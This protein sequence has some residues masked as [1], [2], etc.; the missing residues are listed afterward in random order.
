MLL[1]RE[2]LRGVGTHP[3][4]PQRPGEQ[5]ERLQGLAQVVARGGEKPALRLVGAIGGGAGLVGTR[6]RRL[7]LRLGSL[8]LRHVADR[9]GDQA[10][11]IGHGAQAD[12]RREFGSVAP[13]R[14]QRE[15]GAHR[16]GVR[17]G[18]VGLP[19]AEVTSAKPFRDQ[20]LQIQ[21]DQL[22]MRVAEERRRL[23]IGEADDSVSVDDDQGVRRRI[24]HAA[25]EFSRKSLHGEVG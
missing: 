4:A 19:M 14:E 10:A 24:Q 1:L 15:P 9:G 25:R 20:S 6:A 13:P 16:P 17:R 11:L 21:S 3:H 8:A 23:A 12:L 22:L 7:Q 18:E 5:C 2:H